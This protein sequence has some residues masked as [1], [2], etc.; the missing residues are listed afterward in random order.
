MGHPAVNPTHDGGT[1]MNGPPAASE[2]PAY[3]ATV[4]FSSLFR[5]FDYAAF[6]GTAE[7]CCYSQRSTGEFFG[8][9][10]PAR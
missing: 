9:S 2:V 7:G 1:V 10:D 8:I 3:L 6:C 5:R 4:F